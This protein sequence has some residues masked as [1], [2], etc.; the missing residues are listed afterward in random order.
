MAKVMALGVVQRSDKNGVT[1]LAPKAVFD[2]DGAELERLLS[3]RHVE[4][5]QEDLVAKVDAPLE[6]DPPAKAKKG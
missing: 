2:V 6:V 4:L 5:V 1:E 3:G